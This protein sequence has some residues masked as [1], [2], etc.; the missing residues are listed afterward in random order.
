MF[1]RV[2]AHVHLTHHVAML[3][4]QL[5]KA[6]CVSLHVCEAGRLLRCELQG[7]RQHQWPHT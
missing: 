1:V 2:L 5:L 3:N 6:G 7:W 4:T